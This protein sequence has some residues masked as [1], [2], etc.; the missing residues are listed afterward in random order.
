MLNENFVYIGA[1]LS[2]LGALSYL[3]D[4]LKGKAQPNKVTWFVWALAPLVAL[5]P[6]LQQGVG[7]QSLLTFMVGFNPLLIFLASF[8]NKKAYWKI[9][10]LDLTCGALS[11]LGLVLRKGHQGFLFGKGKCT[12]L[13]SEG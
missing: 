3:I 4:T 5:W 9:T 6:T 10:K 2:F 12:P 11:I 13:R 8:V 7:V 1:A